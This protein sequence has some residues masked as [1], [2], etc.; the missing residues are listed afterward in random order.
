MPEDSGDGLSRINST[1][2]LVPTVRKDPAYYDI[3]PRLGLEVVPLSSPGVSER[4]T[5]VASNH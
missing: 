5:C 2:W 1:C 3:T 4:T